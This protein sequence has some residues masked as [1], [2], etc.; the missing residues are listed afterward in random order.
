[1]ETDSSG[2]ISSPT[3]VQDVDDPGD[4]TQRRFRYQHA[5]GV[6][7]ITAMHSANLPY[8]SIWCEHHDDFL[9]QQ[10]GV[11]DSYQVKT[12]E[13][14][15]GA[16]ELTTDGF[17]AAIAKFVVLETKFAGKFAAFKFVS[18]ARASNSKAEKKMVRSPV[19]LLAA[20]KKTKKEDELEKPFD[21]SLAKM[22]QDC[23]STTACIYSVFKKLELV[24]GP[25]LADFEAV[26]SQIHI[27]QIAACR[28]FPA[29]QLNAIRDE[30]IQKIYDAS[31][32]FVKD[33]AKHWSC[34]NGAASND[35]R[36]QSKR[37]LPSIVD[38]AIKAKSPPYFRFS[39]IATKTDE[40]LTNDNL[41]VLEKKFLRGNL[42]PHMET[43][44]RRTISTEQHLL[45]LA[46]SKPS[47][48]LAIRNQLESKVQAVCDDAILQNTVAPGV[49]VERKAINLWQD[50]YHESAISRIEKSLTSDSHDLQTQGWLEQLAARIAH[51]WGN[52][53]KANALQR[54]AYSHNRNLLRPT[55]RPPYRPVLLVDEQ[56]IAIAK[57]LSEF[58]IR[59]GL[60]KT[61]EDVVSNLHNNASANQF[62]HALASLGNLLGFVAERHDVNGEGPDVLWLMPRNRAWIIEA[63]SRKKQRNPL[64]KDEHGQLLVAAEWFKQNYPNFKFKRVSVHPQNRATRAATASDS[65]ALTYENIARLVADARNLLSRVCESQLPHGQLANDCARLLG[66]SPVNASQL[67]DS[68]LQPFK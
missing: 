67:Y 58:H 13:P 51:H 6:I 24:V 63:K 38:D 49:S 22:S 60:L 42:R 39:P 55:V 14:E 35:P 34:I 11:F 31:S 26:L 9:A 62:E 1:M 52:K 41:S 18:N 64:N 2:N 36:I 8:E 30:L 15:Q 37:L 59:R 40:R 4:E 23:K 54:D 48:I 47:E 57:N 29:Y 50:G 7:L 46:A 21:I 25:S 32:N 19:C 33:P 61:F 5:Y 28:S 20:I 10:N 44:R 68:Y 17:V 65:F 16:W 3:A 53:E 27:A 66:E 45:E 12:R 56:A 43:M